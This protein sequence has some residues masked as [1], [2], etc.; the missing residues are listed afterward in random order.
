MGIVLFALLASVA[1]YLFFHF[2]PQFGGVPDRTRMLQSPNFKGRKFVNHIPTSMALGFA[3]AVS[4]L[5]DYVRHDKG[6]HP[7]R[8]IRVEHPAVAT[9]MAAT[10]PELV[11]FGH[12]ASLLR[13]NG[14]T[15]MLDPMLGTSPFPFPALG[16]KRFSGSLPIEPEALPH[17]DAVLISHDHYDHL[18][19]P[20]IKKLRGKV[21]KFFV[22]LGLA[23]HLLKWGVKP[24]QI[25]EMDWWEEVVFEGFTFVCTP[26]RHFSGRTLTDRFKTLWCSWV[27]TAADIKLFF[28]GDTGYGPHFKQIGKK[29]GPFDLTLMECGQYDERW[30]DI[31]MQPE[32]SL[33]A[34][35]DLRGKRMLPLHWGAFVLAL[36]PWADSVERV[37]IAAK[38]VGTQVVTPKIGEIVRIKAPDY[39]KAAW[40]K[41][42]S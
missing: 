2:Y 20:T 8:P 15:I 25:Q 14:K 21:T 28:S 3:S 41:A 30:P 37:R 33:T 12:S 10:Q 27:I 19:Y 29:Y 38:K 9:I 5:Q 6:K 22:P 4:L 24:E 23:A 1:V 16:P 42:Y 40:W 26:S 7:V 34:H 13:L 18:D 11:W 31:H 39:P 17:I 36:H 35:L 32:Q